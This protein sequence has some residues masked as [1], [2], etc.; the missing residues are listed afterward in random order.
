[1]SIRHTIFRRIGRPNSFSLRAR[2]T[3]IV[4]F[5]LFSGG[6]S[7]YLLAP[8]SRWEI[9]VSV[10]IGVLA[11]WILSNLWDLLLLFWEDKRKIH[12][13]HDDLSE[14]Y[15]A[16]YVRRLELYGDTSTDF[17]Y[18]P[19]FHNTSVSPLRCVAPDA[20]SP[21][22]QPEVG[23]A[24]GRLRIALDDHPERMFRLNN[25]LETLFLKIF[26][27]HRGCFLRNYPTLRLADF[28]VRPVGDG[29]TELRFETMRST[30]FNHLV[31]NR[32]MDFVIDDVVSVRSL[33]EYGPLLKPLRTSDLSNHIGINAIVYLSDGTMLYKQRSGT[34]TISKGMLTSSIAM[35]IDLDEPARPLSAYDL[36]VAP[37][38]QGL[39]DRLGIYDKRTST[40]G[41]RQPLPLDE[42]DIYLLGV[43]RNVYEGGKPHL[44][45]AV[46]MKNLSLDDFLREY[47]DEY[48]RMIRT[49]K[50]DSDRRVY[51]C[52]P[53][54]RAAEG[55]RLRIAYH[56]FEARITR[57]L[58][59]WLT[60]HTFEVEKSF[61]C[62]YWHL[63]ENKALR[64]KLRSDIRA[65]GA[66]HPGRKIY[67]DDND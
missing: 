55:Q 57:R 18:D 48:R 23:S 32:A 37:V 33:F 34:A 11:A 12:E 61:L 62:N 63:L 64:E 56:F 27:A 17:F 58:L 25:M 4:F 8:E 66:R 26:R 15:D 10:V 9:I 45:Y 21:D 54:T 22:G 67:L 39:I 16:S 60:R 31:T 38:R 40:P 13:D 28:A 59:P 14:C 19:L 42:M 5:C 47:M 50:F 3:F 2:K 49:Y 53:Q 41:R 35:K 6:L 52:T 30:Y 1:M 36:L 24:D 29:A 7:I 44:Y 46:Y 20:A 43:G 65:W 51:F